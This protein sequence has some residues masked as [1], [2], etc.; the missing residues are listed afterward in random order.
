[1][2]GQVLAS[3]HAR[4]LVFVAASLTAPLACSNCATTAT[5]ITSGSLPGMPGRPMGQTMRAIRAAAM[6]RASKRCSKRARLVREP[7]RPK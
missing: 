1:M 4:V 6:P 2:S 3:K 7:I 5:A